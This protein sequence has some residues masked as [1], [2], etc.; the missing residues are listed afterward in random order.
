V[1]GGGEDCQLSEAQEPDVLHGKLM[2]WLVFL[3]IGIVLMMG[4]LAEISR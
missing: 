4:V 2:K 1:P 3:V